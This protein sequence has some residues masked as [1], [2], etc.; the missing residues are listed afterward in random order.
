MYIALKRPTAS[1][2]SN[3]NGR[4]RLCQGREITDDRQRFPSGFSVIGPI[5]P[6]VSSIW[7]IV[8]APVKMFGSEGRA[9]WM[10]HNKIAQHKK[11]SPET[12]LHEQPITL[13][14]NTRDHRHAI[15]IR[16][17][18]VLPNSLCYESHGYSPQMVTH[19]T[20]AQMG[21]RPFSLH[22]RR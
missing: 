5:S 19:W 1:L 10:Q 18:P 7:S 21:F 11:H 9:G 14:H 13:S 4:S 15:P 3:E 16:F 8:L 12:V 20:R 17:L 22:I 6:A 2:G